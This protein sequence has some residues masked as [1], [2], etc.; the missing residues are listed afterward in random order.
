MFIKKDAENVMSWFT[1]NVMQTNPENKIQLMT[2]KMYTSNEITSN[3]V[4][5]NYYCYYDAN[6]SKTTWQNN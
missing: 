4:E 1:N 5:I 2:M 3:F 6:I